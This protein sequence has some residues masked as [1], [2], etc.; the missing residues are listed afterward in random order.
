MNKVIYEVRS[1]VCDYGIYKEGKLVSGDLIFSSRKNA[2]YVCIIMNADINKEQL[3]K[4]EVKYPKVYKHFKHNPDGDFNNYTYCTMGISK[5]I[6]ENFI[7]KQGLAYDNN[8][9][10]ESTH[11]KFDVIFNNYKIDG[12]LYHNE[13]FDPNELVIYKSLYDDYIPWAREVS[14]FLSKVP[15]GREEENITGQVYRFEEV[16]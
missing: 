6:S 9:I 13:K 5:P 2:E 3:S 12:V 15:E 14:E 8:D 11:T 16:N 7:Y 4:R 10:I 1:C